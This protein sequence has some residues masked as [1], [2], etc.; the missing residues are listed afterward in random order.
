MKYIVRIFADY[1]NSSALKN[2]YEEICE[3]HKLDYYGPNKEIY[4][5]D[6]D[7]YTH[8][9][10][11]N[12]AT[13]FLRLPKENVVGLANEPPTFLVVLFNKNHF[14]HYA[15][16]HI[17][18]YFVGD[19]GLPPPFMC[20][21]SFLSHI[22][23]LNYKPIKNKLMSII[24][25]EKSLLVDAVGYSY[26]KEILSYILTSDLPIDIYGRIC[27]FITNKDDQRIKGEFEA[28]EPYENY[29][30]HICIENF[31]C[32]SYFSEKV[33]NPLLTNTVPIYLGC[34]KIEEYFGD[35]LIQMSGDVKTDMQLICDVLNYPEKYQKNIDLDLVKSKTSLIQNIKE[36]FS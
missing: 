22:T 29:Q 16:K 1:A 34:T 28:Y 30:F 31:R 33:I 17:G 21:Y 20:K 2:I 32:E 9:I 24:V 11:I 14:V 5:T 23:P 12:N 13:P 3:A 26:R 8:A 36:I 15:S 19:R 27:K 7:N 10:V 6:E 35:S 4:I 18:K 25:S